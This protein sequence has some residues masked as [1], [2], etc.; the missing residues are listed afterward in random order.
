MDRPDLNCGT[1]VKVPDMFS[2]ME[3]LEKSIEAVRSATAMIYEHLRLSRSEKEVGI[4]TK[5]EQPPLIVERTRYL[6]NLKSNLYHINSYLEE[7][8]TAIREI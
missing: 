3:E 1:V 8:L 6:E 5:E 4:S 2:T 7:I